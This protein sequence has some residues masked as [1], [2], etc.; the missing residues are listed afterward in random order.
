MSGETR[1]QLVDEDCC[2][3]F[4]SAWRSGIRREI[5]DCLP[6]PDSS[7]YLPTL[8][9]LVCIRME[10]QWQA[11]R[12]SRERT[13]VAGSAETVAAA[14]PQKV[15]DYVRQFPQLATAPIYQ[16]LI[17]QEYLIRRQ[18]GDHVDPAEYS[19]R[20]PDRKIEDL[21]GTEN[22]ATADGLYESRAPLAEAPLPKIDGYEFVR[23]LGSGGMGV[24]FLA[25]QLAADRLVAVKLIRLDRLQTVSTEDRSEILERFRTEAQATAKLE[26]PHVVSVYEV[27]V[28][29]TQ[30]PWFSMQYVEGTTLQRE[31]SEGPLTPRQ[32]A[33]YT[34]QIAAAVSAAHD[35][36]ILHRDLKPQNVF[37]RQDGRLLVGDFGLAKLVTSDAQQTSA[38]RILGTPAYMSPEQIKD[39]STVTAAT[40]IWSIGTILYRML[41]G[42]P[43]FQAAGVMETLRQVTEHQPVAPREI[44]P[45][46]DRD[47]DTIC[48]KCLQ[49]DADQRYASVADLQEDLRRYLDGHAIVARPVSRLEHSVRWCRRNPLTAAMILLAAVGAAAAITGLAIGY[50]TA[51]VALAESD[52]SH[53]MARATVNDLLTE[54]SET[55]LFDR[56][57][58][59]PLRRRLQQKT[60]GY[61]RQFV[62]T[63]RDSPLVKRELAEVWYR[64]A[65]IE[66][67]LGH[68]SEAERAFRESTA[69]LRPLSRAEQP[70]E[71]LALSTTLNGHAALHIAKGEWTVATSLLQEA[72]A[73]RTRLVERDEHNVEYGRLRANTVM[74]QGAVFRNTEDVNQAIDCFS[75]ARKAYEA[76]LTLPMSDE[77]SALVR[78]D[79]AKAC[80]NL[81]NAAFDANHEDITSQLPDYLNRA[82]ELFT[83]LC[84]EFPDSYGDRRRLI[85]CQQLQAE[86][87]IVR[88]DAMLAIEAAQ[89]SMETLIA[90]NPAVPQLLEERQ[91]LVL[92]KVDVLLDLQEFDA[93]I[94]LLDAQAQQGDGDPQQ[95]LIMRCEAAL[96]CCQLRRDDAASRLAAVTDQLKTAVAKS[97]DDEQLQMLLEDVQQAVASLSP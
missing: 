80:Y 87:A 9:E 52:R 4:E 92:A 37:V 66:Q 10:L 91:Q 68:D 29:D 1:L 85:L 14:W 33:A 83:Q 41:T 93:A 59:Q 8:E 26:H 23:Q 63:G 31:L 44:N 81:A 88:T 94:A 35:R 21:L 56:P 72:L 77:Q 18:C 79:L 67:E 53:D 50:H 61:Y 7:R 5:H 84:D 27:D 34:Q 38:D 55:M 47:I 42:R 22:L 19:R 3:E 30:Q 49:K 15:E 11:L 46:L 58:L 16:R 97:A 64:I 20:F 89:R 57:G 69:I 74:N 96:L 45:Q 60:L 76:L 73:L 95:R 12:R 6:A 51:S 75:T 48:M 86:T 39:A 62:S 90:Q 36:G 32:C 43:P 70:A 40:D 54:V 71:L 82:I 2:A 13:T 28:G 25:R 65:R 78:R 24:V 17:R